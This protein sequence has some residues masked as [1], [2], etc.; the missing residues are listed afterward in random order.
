VRLIV[1]W[2]EIL[3]AVDR[4]PVLAAIASGIILGLLGFG[5]Q[6]LLNWWRTR[7]DRETWSY[8]TRDILIRL[9]KHRDDIRLRKRKERF[10]PPYIADE[11]WVGNERRRP[12]D[13]ERLVP[14]GLV[15]STQLKSEST[16]EGGVMIDEKYVLTP[17]G[18]RL[19][20]RFMTQEERALS[21]L[22]K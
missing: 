15:R 19:G 16:L 5:A 11:A 2:S 7:E 14:I 17:L 9:Y 22:P 8:E 6:A 18:L 21:K 20:K 10:E 12:Y 3:A 13:L 4:S 1:G